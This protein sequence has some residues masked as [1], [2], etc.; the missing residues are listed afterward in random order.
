M[1]PPQRVEEQKKTIVN[2]PA[3]PIFQGTPIHTLKL[4]S[5]CA[6]LIQGNGEATAQIKTAYLN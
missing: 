2:H 3:S 6:F 1:K 5:I 4:E